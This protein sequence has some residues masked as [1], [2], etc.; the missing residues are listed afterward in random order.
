MPTGGVECRLSDSCTLTRD[1]GSINQSLVGDKGSTP[2]SGGQ[3]PAKTESCLALTTN[4]NLLF[5]I[6]LSSE[7]TGLWKSALTL[8][9]SSGSGVARCEYLECIPGAGAGQ[10]F[11]Q[12]VAVPSISSE[13]SKEIWK[14][15][16]PQSGALHRSICGFVKS[17]M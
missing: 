12:P 8:F 15:T 4:K 11:A 13:G 5:S 10:S 16:L 9:H 2:Q 17:T 1:E 14:E 6:F 7:G 3:D